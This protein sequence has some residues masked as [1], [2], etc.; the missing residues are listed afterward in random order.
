MDNTIVELDK[1]LQD[2]SN[3]YTSLTSNVI[4]SYTSDLDD[5]I[6]N[7]YNDIQNNNI[8]DNTLEM[9]ALN[10]A[11]TLYFIGARLEETG[12]LEDLSKMKKQEKYNQV[13]LETQLK[14][15]QGNI[16][17]TTSSLQSQAEEGSKYDSMLNSIYD[18][19]YKAVKGKLDAAYELLSTIKKIIS[20]RMTEAQL[21]FAEKPQASKR[22]LLED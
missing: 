8:D 22:I 12:V 16:K 18:H 19:V 9:H 10:L 2:L 3:D 21:A 1:N 13:Y 4:T 14:A 20:K 15:I 11:S 17:T 5:M 6:K 7:I